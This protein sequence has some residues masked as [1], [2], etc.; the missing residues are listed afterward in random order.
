M[1]IA[2]SAL[3]LSYLSLLVPAQSQVTRPDIMGCEQSCPV[4]AA[5]FPMPYVI[6]GVVSPVNSVSINPFDIIFLNLDEF[7]LI[8]FIISYI[9]WLALVLIALKLYRIQHP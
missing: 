2:V 9:F 7:V 5:G 3:V 1:I 6:D 8:N 4:V